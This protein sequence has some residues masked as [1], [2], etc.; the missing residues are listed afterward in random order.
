M[1][2]RAAELG[3]TCVVEPGM[4]GGTRVHARLPLQTA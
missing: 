3:G 4:E 2:E 1:Q